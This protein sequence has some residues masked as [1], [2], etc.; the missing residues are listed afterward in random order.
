[1]N[2]ASCQLDGVEKILMK[3][4][5]VNN[6]STLLTKE[7]SI[8]KFVRKFPSLALDSN[9]VVN[10]TA[11][12]SLIAKYSNQDKLVP[13]KVLYQLN[14]STV[15]S[16]K[17]DYS[18]LTSMTANRGRFMRNIGFKPGAII[19][20]N[21]NE[22]KI[23]VFV[24]NFCSAGANDFVETVNNANCSSSIILDCSLRNVWLN[25]QLIK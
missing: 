6:I 25:C 16:M 21:Y 24:V 4:I 19:V 23:S 12:S 7:V 5:Y 18:L 8:K 10:M 14:Y 1:M 3:R 9:T 15:A 17:K 11:D 2:Q 22:K 13:I 20:P